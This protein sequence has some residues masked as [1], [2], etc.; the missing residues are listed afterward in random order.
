MDGL[1]SPHKWVLIRVGR[2]V[3]RKVSESECVSE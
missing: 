1:I 2:Y 3:G